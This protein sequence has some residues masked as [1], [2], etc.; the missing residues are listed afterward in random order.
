LSLH[1]DEHTDTEDTKWF[2]RISKALLACP[3]DKP[4]WIIGGESIYRDALLMYI[5]DFIDVTIMNFIHIGPMK[6]SVKVSLEKSAN[7][8]HIP[9]VY[10]VESEVQNEDDPVLWHRRYVKRPGGFGHSFL[11]DI[12]DESKENIEMDGEET[13][14]GINITSIR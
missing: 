12:R 14:K 6:D 8:P 11:E 7:L 5:P 3:E 1:A 4:I 10:M 13:D 2:R 9:Y